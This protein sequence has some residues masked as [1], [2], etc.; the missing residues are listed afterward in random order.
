MPVAWL[1]TVYRP[2]KDT[3]MVH[4]RRLM[5]LRVAASNDIARHHGMTTLHSL[6]G[7][8]KGLDAAGRLF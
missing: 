1:E 2:R 6:Y 7:H 4:H 8:N 3:N 5:W